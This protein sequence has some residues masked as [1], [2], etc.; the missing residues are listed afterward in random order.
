LAGANNDFAVSALTNGVT[1]HLLLNR[2]LLTIFAVGF[3]VCDGDQN[4]GA[5]VSPYM[6]FTAENR[7]SL[8]VLVV[9]D[10]AGKCYQPCT[11]ACLELDSGLSTVKNIFTIK[12]LYAKT[13]FR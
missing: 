6:K 3:M 9:E 10:S 7:A 8:C 1:H 13:T 2:T 4:R 5:M 11:V 12:Q